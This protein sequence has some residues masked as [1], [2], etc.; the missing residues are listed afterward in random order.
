MEAGRLQFGRAILTLAFVIA[1]HIFAPMA[2]AVDSATAKDW[3]PVDKAYLLVKTGTPQPE[4]VAALH[5]HAREGSSR[6]AVILGAAYL[7]GTAVARNNSLG[8]AWLEFVADDPTADAFSG[9][10]A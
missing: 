7:E 6:A 1:C 4:A 2:R 9:E 10:P 8:F 5:K 3:I